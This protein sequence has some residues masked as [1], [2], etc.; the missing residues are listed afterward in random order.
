MKRTDNITAYH[1]WIATEKY[2]PFKVKFLPDNKPDLSTFKIGESIGCEG[3]EAFE[4]N[5]G[6]VY[7]RATN[8]KK[9]K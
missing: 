3:L 9:G 1:V 6:Q 7:F 2:N 8:I 5:Y 4:N